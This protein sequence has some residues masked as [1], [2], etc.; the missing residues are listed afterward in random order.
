MGGRLA[1][2]RGAEFSSVHAAGVCGRYTYTHVPGDEIDELLSRYL[3]MHPSPVRFVRVAP[4]TYIWGR[5]RCL[6]T[7]QEAARGNKK[8]EISVDGG[9]TWRSLNKFMEDN[10]SDEAQLM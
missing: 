5:H 9:L 8:L 1:H 4:N 6:L 7:V 2:S 10:M 3:E